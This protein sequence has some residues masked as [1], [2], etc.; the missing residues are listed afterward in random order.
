MDFAFKVSGRTSPSTSPWKRWSV[1]CD[2]IIL[3]SRWLC[4]RTCIYQARVPYESAASAWNRG[5]TVWYSKQCD[6]PYAHAYIATPCSTRDPTTQH[7]LEHQTVAPDFR[8]K[9]LAA[10]G[11]TLAGVA[12]VFHAGSSL[13]KLRVL[14]RI[15]IASPPRSR[16]KSTARRRAAVSPRAAIADGDLLVHWNWCSLWM[17]RILC[18]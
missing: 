14:Q 4:R 13:S 5:A 10:R 17:G 15:L 1:G 9:S 8:G 7:G 12:C 2:Q 16:V 18:S 6:H 11:E 3:A